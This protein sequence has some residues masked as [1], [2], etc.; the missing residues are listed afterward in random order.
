M[1]RVTSKLHRLYSNSENLNSQYIYLAQLLKPFYFNHLSF[2]SFQCDSRTINSHQG[3]VTCTNNSLRYEHLSDAVQEAIEEYTLSDNPKLCCDKLE[4]ILFQ[5]SLSNS[6]HAS[7]LPADGFSLH[8]CNHLSLMAYMTLAS[9]YRLISQISENEQSFKFSR[10]SVAYS[11]LQCF[12]AYH[13]F[14]CEPSLVASTSHFLLSAGEA[15][16]NLFGNQSLEHSITYNSQLHVSGDS[17]SRVEFQAITRQFVDCVSELLLQCWPFLV[18]NFL[19]LENIKSPMDFNWAGFWNNQHRVSVSKK[20]CVAC[21][22]KSEKFDEEQK[23]YLYTLAVHCL[24]H[25]R[26]LANIC[27]GPNCHLIEKSKT[28]LNC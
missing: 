4:I 7:E 14:L 2:F 13:L 18:Q 15:M 16:L 8:P 21:E 10:V 24:I 23:K 20:Q 19:Y 27:Y 1:Y 26:Y 17:L 11:T 9:A 3:T 6:L 12:S 5:N 25:G 28:L 22:L